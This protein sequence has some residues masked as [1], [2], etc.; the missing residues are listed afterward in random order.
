MSRE[1]Q[2]YEK[3]TPKHYLPSV[4]FQYISVRTFTE[5]LRR[6]KIPTWWLMGIPIKHQTT[7]VCPKI[8]SSMKG[9]TKACGGSWGSQKLEDAPPSTCHLLL[10]DVQP[11]LPWPQAHSHRYEMVLRICPRKG[12]IAGCT[13]TTGGKKLVLSTANSEVGGYLHA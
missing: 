13:P 10:N 1:G 6:C 9:S 2:K 8:T 4:I 7:M 11:S 3:E 12:V 5:D